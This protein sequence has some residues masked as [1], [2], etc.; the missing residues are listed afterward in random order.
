M[1][2]ISDCT[3]NVFI[4]VKLLGLQ[5]ASANLNKEVNLS[6]KLF[7]RKILVLSELQ[8]VADVG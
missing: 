1:N 2:P 8:N 4:K 7:L 3:S 5:I 6:P